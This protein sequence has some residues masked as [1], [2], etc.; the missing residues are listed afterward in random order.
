MKWKGI[1]AGN[2]SSSCFLRSIYLINLDQYSPAIPTLRLQRNNLKCPPFYFVT[3]IQFVA[4][5]LR[6][7]LSNR[8]SAEQIPRDWALFELYEVL[9]DNKD[10]Y[11]HNCSYFSWQCILLCISSLLIKTNIST[12]TP[13]IARLTLT[14]F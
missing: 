4:C 1:D 8:S 11:S 9:L 12:I 7:N 5:E 13:N 6:E 2:L 14:F 3:S 10:I